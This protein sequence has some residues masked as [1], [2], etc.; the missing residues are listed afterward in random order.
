MKIAIIGFGNLGRSLAEG[1]VKS[2]T[3]SGSEICVCDNAPEARALAVDKYGFSVTDDVNCA[4]SAA[5]VIFLVVKSYVFEV[6]APSIDRDLL[7]GKTVVSFMAGITFD[8]IF[9]LIG[10]V[11]LVRGMPSLAIA[12]CDG[13]VAYTKA[14]PHVTDIFHKLG[15]AFEATPEDIEKVMAFSSCGLGFAAYLIDAFATAGKHMGFAP[16]ICAKIAA[17]TF[18]NAVD[19]GDWKNTVKAVATK[20]GATEQGILHMDASNVYGIITEAVQ[21]AYNRMK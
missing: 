9:A 12:A 6:L 5:E 18:K 2:G 3:A 1:L 10:K 21:K 4:I 20:G 11:D 13:V 16:D 15:Y 8:K 14:P 17:Q 7:T 19:R